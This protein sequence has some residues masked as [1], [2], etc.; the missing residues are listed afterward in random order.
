MAKRSRRS[1][2]PLDD[3]PGLFDNIEIDLGHID[4]PSGGNAAPDLR[5][6]S[7]SSAGE[8][9]EM[10]HN[11]VKAARKVNFM[12]LGSGSSGNCA[13]IGTSAGGLLI[14]AGVDN[15][16]VTER[17]LANGIDMG[18]VRGIILTHDHSDHVRFAYSLLR[19]NPHMALFATP[20]TLN[21]L[22]R[23]HNI[24]R[25]IK[26]YH[27]AIYIETPFSAGPFSVTAFGVSHDGSDNVGFMIEGEGLRFVVATDMGEITDRADHYMRQA[28]ALMLESN[29][30]AT[31][32]RT[33]R[34]PEYLKARIAGARGHLDNEVAAAKLAEIWTERLRYVF[35]CH[36]SNDNNTPEVALEASRL[37]L[38][39]RGISVG[40]GSGSLEARGSAVQLTALPR[41]GCCPLTVIRPL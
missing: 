7:G 21:G 1:I 17:L 14:D 24:S 3:L 36:L 10:D 37:A 23:R 18:S 29:Y 20:R 39:G 26:D 16:F 12:S 41:Y 40:D 38:T 19:R 13:Y 15:K 11:A 4:M 32:L 6:T 5:K 30:D 8:H 35:L 22:L 9:M 25:R 27:H 34:Y 31:M 2:R 28:D 33:G